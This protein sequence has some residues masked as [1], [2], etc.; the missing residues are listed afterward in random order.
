MN[1][2]FVD[3][4]RSVESLSQFE[5]KRALYEGCC[6]LEHLCERHL[7]IHKK[8]GGEHCASGQCDVCKW[9]TP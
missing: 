8:L 4:E 3:F 5:I 9:Q 1:R 2:M 7:A 6:P